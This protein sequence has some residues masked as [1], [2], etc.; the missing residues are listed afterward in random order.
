MAAELGLYTELN[1][2]EEAIAKLLQ[3]CA[4]INSSTQIHNPHRNSKTKK[5]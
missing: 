4:M 2:A 5:P 3:K 1:N